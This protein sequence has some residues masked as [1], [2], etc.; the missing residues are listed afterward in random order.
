MEQD[1]REGANGSEK[2]GYVE[3]GATCWWVKRYEPKKPKTDNGS[4]EI[5]RQRKA[6]TSMK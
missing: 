5:Q 3:V 6:R 4:Q 2:H 1:H